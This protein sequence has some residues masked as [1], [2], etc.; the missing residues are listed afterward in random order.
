M[1]KKYIIR[2]DDACERMDVEAWQRIEDL[3]Q[4]Y[5]VR[6]LVGVIPHCEDE[7]MAKYS[8]DGSFWEKVKKWQK[9]G[10]VFAL[11]GY[12][13]VYS[14]SSGGINPVNKRSEFAGNSYEVQ[15]GKIREGVKIFLEHG[16]EP[17][18]FFAPSHTFD[19]NTLEALKNESKIRIISD[20]WAGSPYSRYGFTI[21][22]QQ[23]GQVRNLPFEVCT[24]CYHPNTMKESDFEKLESFLTKYANRFVRFPIKQVDRKLSL[25]EIALQKMYYMTRK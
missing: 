15:A 25:W 13:H 18:V 17:E 5:N 20:T 8:V 2:L 1:N 11:H 9:K 24:F 10:W 4:T 7:K 21:V 12:N 6:P 3:L 19:K 22:P 16:I 23:S 14:T